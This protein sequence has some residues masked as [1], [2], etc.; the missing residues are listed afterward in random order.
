MT[1]RAKGLYRKHIDRLVGLSGLFL[2]AAALLIIVYFAVTVPVEG[3][4]GERYVT[5]VIAPPYPLDEITTFKP[6]TLITYFTFCEIVLIIDAN[7]SRLAI[8]N[9]RGLRAVLLTASFA[10]GYEFIWNM[11][12]WFTTWLKNGGPLD[13]TANLYHGNSFP[14]VNFNFATKI[15]FLVFATCLYCWN[16]L[17]KLA[18]EDAH[19]RTL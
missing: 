18:I 12:A 17:R 7:K 2:L 1:G 15:C 8:I 16:F 10:A 9:K 19:G 6:V 3:S 11:F 14:A 4:F 13:L 5:T